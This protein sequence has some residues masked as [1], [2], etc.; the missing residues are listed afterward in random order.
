MGSESRMRGLKEG[1][2]TAVLCDCTVEKERGLT[3]CETDYPPHGNRRR[4]EL[5]W[6]ETKW[7]LCVSQL[8]N[9]TKRV[10]VD[11]LFIL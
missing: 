1:S 11:F 2:L 10:Y 7:I 9:S 5:V 8:P 4:F 3:F 6:S